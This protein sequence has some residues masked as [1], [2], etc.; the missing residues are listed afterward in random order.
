MGSDFGNWEET[1]IYTVNVPH[2]EMPMTVVTRGQYAACVEAGASTAPGAL[3]PHVL[4]SSED[5]ND[6]FHEDRNDHPI[7]CVNWDQAA[8]FYVWSV[9][10]S[11]LNR[12]G[13]TPRRVDSVA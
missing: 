12:N 11:R 8:D 6:W 13:N 5:V 1:P 7:N 3:L 10:G 9:D 4:T 2:F